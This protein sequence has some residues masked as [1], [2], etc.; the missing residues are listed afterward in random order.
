MMTLIKRRNISAL[1]LAA[2]VFIFCQIYF[3]ICVPASFCEEDMKEKSLK[4]KV[5]TIQYWGNVWQKKPLSERLAKAPDDLIEKLLLDNQLE[6]F[7]EI[8]VPAAPPTEFSAAIKQVEEFL[9]EQVAVLA[10]NRI[11]G[12][13]AVTNLGGSGYVESVLDENGVEKYTFIVLDRDVLLKRKAN[14]WATWKERS[15]FKQNAGNHIEL[16]VKIESGGNDNTQNAIV[17][18]LLHEIGHSL[19]LVSCAHASWTKKEIVIGPFS[20]LSWYKRDNEIKSVFDGVFPER[21]LIKPYAF[22]N[23]TLTE[24]QITNIYKILNTRTN[25]PTIHAA[26]DIWEDFA[27]SFVSYIHVVR[28]N[29]PYEIRIGQTGMPDIMYTSCWK[30]SRCKDKRAFMDQWFADPLSNAQQSSH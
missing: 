17:Y 4:H 29:K 18:I 3:L 5:R 16:D 22:D 12:I 8:P 26:T 19:G 28:E 23:S 24:N 14:E 30:N 27:E 25:Y 13:F 1:F 10:K 15:I 11:I 7:K 6:G 9:P 2:M 20:R 21:K